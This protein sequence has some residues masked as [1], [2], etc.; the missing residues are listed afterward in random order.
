MQARKEHGWKAS[1]LAPETNWKYALVNIRKVFLYSFGSSE[2]KPSR[3]I[4]PSDRD[5]DS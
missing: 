5:I 2:K 4:K 1:P 3:A